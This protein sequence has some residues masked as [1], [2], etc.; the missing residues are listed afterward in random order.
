[1]R[2][3]TDK[4]ASFSRLIRHDM[5]ATGLSSRAATLP[6]L[7]TQ[8]QDA[9]AV[10]DA[11]GSR[12]TVILGAGPGAHTASLFAATYPGRTR[13][14]VLWDLLRVGRRRV[15]AERPGSAGPHLGHGGF[16]RRRDGAGGALDDRRSRVPQV[17]LQGAAPLRP[18]GRRGRPAA[19]RDRHGH[20]SHAPRDPRPDPGLGEELAGLRRRSQGRRDDRG[21]DV[22]P[23][24]RRGPR[25]VRR[26]PGRP[27]RR[28]P[29][30]RGGG[31]PRPPPTRSFARC[32]SP[33][34]SARPSTFPGSETRRGAS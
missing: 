7:E 26:P 25:D 20:P 18:A 23:A 22:R 5:R 31:R 14:L 1:M 28:G 9:V 19:G 16:G 2:S 34:S 3:I 29:R 12:S 21:I 24:G 6:N 4:V 10:L 8:V 33:T 32:S 11:V 15:P 27:G 30:L 17:V 13:A